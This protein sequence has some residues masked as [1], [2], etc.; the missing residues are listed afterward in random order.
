MNISTCLW[1]TFISLTVWINQYSLSCIN[2]NHLMPCIISK[3][4]NNF[5]NAFIH[6]FSFLTFLFKLN[7]TIPPYSSNCEK[8]HWNEKMLLTFRHANPCQTWIRFIISNHFWNYSEVYICSIRT[9]SLTSNLKVETMKSYSIIYNLPLF[10][11]FLYYYTWNNETF[12][13]E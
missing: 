12:C 3:I 9:S 11:Y 4:I 1:F 8:Q 6:L 7:N 5:N 13:F 2:H 10:K